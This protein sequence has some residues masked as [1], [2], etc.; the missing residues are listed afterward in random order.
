MKHENNFLY[1][2]LLGAIAGTVTPQP[3]RTSARL[4]S[5][6][7]PPLPRRLRLGGTSPNRVSQKKRR[8]YARRVGK[9]VE[10]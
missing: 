1:L 9:R 2:S 7:H 8:L 3:V 5:R 4:G 10:H 6:Y